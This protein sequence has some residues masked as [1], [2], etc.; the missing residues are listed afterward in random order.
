M[1]GKSFGMIKIEAVKKRKE[2]RQEVKQDP[3]NVEKKDK[4]IEEETIGQEKERA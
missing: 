3:G 4:W 2:A 1:V